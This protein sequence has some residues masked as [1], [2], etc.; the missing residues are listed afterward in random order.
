MK[1]LEKR[2]VQLRAA[3]LDPSKCVCKAPKCEAVQ[4]DFDKETTWLPAIKDATH[5]FFPIKPLDPS[6]MTYFAPLLELCKKHGVKKIVF[7]SALNPENLPIVECEEALKKSGINYTILRSPFFMENLSTGFMRDEVDNGC[8]CTPS[9]DHPVSFVSVQ[10]IGECIANTLL[11]D[12]FNDQTIEVTGPTPLT[13]KQCAD[14]ISKQL[15]K[16]IKYN[17]VKDDEFYQTNKSKGMSQDV[18]KVLRCIY[19]T[20]NQDK[21]AKVTSGAQQ[22]TGH[23]PLSFEHFV[24]NAFTKPSMPSQ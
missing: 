3:L 10:D 22:I 23:Q 24:Q 4:F 12:K 14:M 16:P 17:C 18:V 20:V 19:D 13:F 2:D 5:V 8:L 21:N 9:G 7:L 1:A 11:D 6:P 15:N